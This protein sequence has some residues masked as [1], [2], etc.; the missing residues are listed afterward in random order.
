[1]A[2]VQW[3]RS[4]GTSWPQQLANCARPVVCMELAARAHMSGNRA[5]QACRNVSHRD[6]QEAS[7]CP[8][9]YERMPKVTYEK[10]R[11]TV[12]EG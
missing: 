12:L 2:E 3:L 8:S 7:A 6:A 5:L 1:M 11:N 9:S 4:L 10:V